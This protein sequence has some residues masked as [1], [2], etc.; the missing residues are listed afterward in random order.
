MA[1]KVKA[2][3]HAAL[4]IWIA[5]TK[6]LERFGGLG[7]SKTDAGLETCGTAGSEACV[8]KD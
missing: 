1:L 6:A 5:R 8:T 2:A 7:A 4:Q 3:L